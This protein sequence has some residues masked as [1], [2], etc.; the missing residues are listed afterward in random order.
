MW[1][2][3]DYIIYKVNRIHIQSIIVDIILKYIMYSIEQYISNIVQYSI[4]NVSHM[5]NIY[6]MMM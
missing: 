3:I 6:I 2:N 5:K 4:Y 1:S